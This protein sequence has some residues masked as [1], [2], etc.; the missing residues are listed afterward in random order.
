VIV[1]P[2]G[3]P[4]P[5]VGEAVRS[6]WGFEVTS[7]EH[8]E[9][10]AGAWHWRVCVG[11][12]PEWFA[13]VEAVGTAEERQTLLAAYEATIALAPRLPFAVPP[14]RTR[15]ARVA[16]DVAPGLL[17]S[18]TPFLEGTAGGGPMDDDA[19]R[20]S[21]AG[22]LGALH[23]HP[24]PRHLPAWRPRIGWHARAGREELERCLTLEQWSGGPWSVPAAR[25]LADARPVVERS[26]RRFALLGAA[27]AGTVDRW[28][29]THG[30]PHTANLVDTPDGPRLVDWATLRLAPRERDL[31][32]VLG[33]AEG[34]EPWFA[35]VEA[36]GSPDPL[37][38]DTLEL[39]ALQWHLSEIAEYAVRFS[40]SH[41]DTADER[42][43]FG[44]LESE[45]AALF[46]RWA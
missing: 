44:D 20:S 22:L 34:S 46:A 3:L 42:R 24:R 12:G 40:R 7:V 35:Y 14:V 18:L 31:R 32:E 8:L 27:V 11:D 37:S 6:A 17:L 30:E 39:F 10:G 1:E 33:E 19:T 36:G 38:P 4:G 9:L 28:V 29:V 43:C 25:M 26:M 23:R 2:P 21:V 5:R 16:V 45:V 15:D 41:E 13:T